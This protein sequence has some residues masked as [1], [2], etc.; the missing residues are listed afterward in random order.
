MATSYD[1][2]F[3]TISSPPFLSNTTNLFYVVPTALADNTTYYYKVVSRN[4]FGTATGTT[5]Y[6]FTTGTSANLNYCTYGAATS[7]TPYGAN[8]VQLTPASTQYSAGCTWARVPISFSNPFDYECDVYLGNENGLGSDGITLTFQNS[9]LGISACGLDGAQKGAGGIA[10][11]LI[12]EIDTYD[13]D[14]GA[15]NDDPAYDHIAVETDGYL[16]DDPTKPSTWPHLPQTPAFGPVQALPGGANV[17]DGVL[18][19]LRV[20]WNPV[21]MNLNVYFDG[22]LALTCH[23]DFVNTVFGGN[24]NVFWGFTA[25]TGDATNEHYICPVNMPLPVNLLNFSVECYNDHRL[26]HW[27]TA[28]EI[29]NHYFTIEKTVDGITYNPL[30]TIA[31]V[32]NS[33]GINEYQF[34]DEESTCGLAYYKLSQTDFD[35]KSTVLGTI[36]SDCNNISEKLSITSIRV[37]DDGVLEVGVS[38]KLEGE[39][40]FSIFNEVGQIQ[41]FSSVHLFAGMQ[42]INIPFEK[43]G[44]FLLNIKSPYGHESRYFVK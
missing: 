16:V 11:S 14:G 33:S 20:T 26:L 10:N 40:L 15:L 6:S 13:N 7:S 12:V 41:F 4:N 35:G 19:L 36:Q 23:E 27:Q 22:N 30:A 43:N 28:S 29:N 37:K 38:T 18:R 21:T 25:A 5:I 3:G 24:P 39:Y 8:C 44:V 32:G 17:D 9:P 2:Y 31:A 34:E 42:I 1:I